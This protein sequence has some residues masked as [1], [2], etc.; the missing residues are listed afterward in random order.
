MDWIMGDWLNLGLVAG[1]AVL[2]YTVAALGLRLG[3]RRTLAQ[4]T[5]IDF[6]TAVAIGAIVVRTAIAAN[7][8]FT[9]GAAALLTLVAAH[10]VVSLLRFPPRLRKL[11]DHPVRVLV[12]DGSLCLTQLRK[13]GLTENDV[14]AHLRQKGVGELDELKYLLYE[15]RGQLTIVRRDVAGTPRLIQI[16]LDDSV[17]FRP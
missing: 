14:F 10:R 13:C 9:T 17:D 15:S 16:A 5:I 4:W 12:S 2:M 8:S 1:K 7:Q 6:V 11:F 3:E